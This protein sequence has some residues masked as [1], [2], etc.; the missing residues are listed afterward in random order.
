MH[1][2]QPEQR[3][4]ASG[5]TSRR[6]IAMGVSGCGKSTIGAALAAR[7]GG[8]FIDGDQYHA[9]E[10]VAKMSRGEPLDDEDRAGWLMR[11]AELI[12]EYRLRDETVIIACSSLKR[13]YRDLLRQGDEAL[14]FVHLT[15]SR[16]LLLSRLQTRTDHFFQGEAM[17]DNQLAT[18]E[19]PGHDEAVA[20][21]IDASLEAVVAACLTGLERM[22]CSPSSARRADTSER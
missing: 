11:L 7:L 2:Q 15:G 9:P 18:L 22:A 20:V 16:E 1:Q 17:L 6:I 13:R 14:C 12:A 21:D 3:H 19:T 8:V 5:D 10:S 4:D